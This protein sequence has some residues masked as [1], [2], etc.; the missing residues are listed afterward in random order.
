MYRMRVDYLRHPWGKFQD[1]HG[2]QL[3]CV[4]S[5]FDTKAYHKW[6]MTFSS[7]GLNLHDSKGSLREF[8][9]EAFLICWNHKIVPIPSMGLVYLPIHEWLICMVNEG[10]HTIHGCYGI[11]HRKT[12]KY[13]SQVTFSLH[14]FEQNIF[15][16]VK[17][18][19][20]VSFLFSAWRPFQL[21]RFASW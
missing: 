3:P 4:W 11:N 16:L 6:I 8:L 14:S 17:A 13:M 1:L 19:L 9:F 21:A 7:H 2:M 15:F 5:N 12:S 10:K 18:L 20:S